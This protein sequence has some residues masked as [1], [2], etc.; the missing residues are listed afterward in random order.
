MYQQ[1]ITRH[2]RTAFVIA[3]DQSLSMQRE[4]TFNM[5]CMSKASAVA[6]I[7]DTII[8]ELILRAHRDNGVRDYY[9]IAILGYAD[10]EVY[11]LIDKNRYFIPVAEFDSLKSAPKTYLIDRILPDGS[12]H[13]HK[14]SC[15]TW[16][17]PKA[18]GNTP[19]YEAM[20][21]IREL[22]SEWCSKPQNAESFPPI[23]FNIT[24]GEASDCSPAELI[25]I[26][27]QIRNLSTTDGNVLL[28]NIH[29]SSGEY[30]PSVIFPSD[31]EIDPD[32]H[33]IRL[34]ADCSSIMPE[35]FDALIRSQRGVLAIPPFHAMSYNASLTELI[36]MLNI[37]SRSITNLQ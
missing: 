26:S 4:V 15:H 16:I 21:Q 23:I 17:T 3:I 18:S 22:V 1:E 27:E 32:N 24:D 11:P 36:A 25:A 19:M 34:L 13:Q 7:T 33:Y 8:N 10:N 31:D 2:H 30:A 9:D 12:L 35:Q 28:I 29:L 5:E 14:E 37:G 6:R 20:M